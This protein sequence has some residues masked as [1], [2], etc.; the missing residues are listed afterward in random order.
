MHMFFD[1]V[2]SCNLKCPSCPMG[3]SENENSKKAMQLDLFKQIIKKAAAE[4]VTSI[5]LYN[6]TEPMLHPKI[7]EFIAE[8]QAAGIN[9]GLSSNLNIVK[10]LE[11]AITANPAFFRIS[12]SGFY[13]ETYKIGHAGGDIEQVKANMILLSELKARLNATTEVEVY[14]HRYVH[15]TDEEIL[16]KNFSE[17]L[18]FSFSSGYSVMMPLEKTFAVINGEDTLSAADI[19]ILKRLALPPATDVIDAAK[20]HGNVACTLKDS[21]IVLDCEGNVILCCTIFNQLEYSVGK[22][23]DMPLSTITHRKNTLPKCTSMCNRCTHHGLHVYAMYPNLGSLAENAVNRILTYKY[24]QLA[25]LPEEV[26]S[27][28]KI[29][30]RDQFDEETY[31]NSNSDVRTAVRNGVFP[32]GYDHYIR[33][34]K[35]ENRPGV[36]TKQQFSYTE[37]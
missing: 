16:M 6:W 31:L 25:N 21:M 7:G 10:N 24:R 28:A 15:N 17:Q 19:A 26:T 27:V 20:H 5:H 23:L 18:G 35:I 2:G 13:Q 4:G 3:N 1:I 11:K 33:Y 9:C 34:G 32:S 8:V 37:I 36:V 14:Y 29:S 12:L 30:A 22:Y